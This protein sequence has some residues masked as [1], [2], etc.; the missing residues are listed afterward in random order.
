VTEDWQFCFFVK[1]LIAPEEGVAFDNVLI[2]GIPQVMMR[3]FSS[4]CQLRMQMMIK[5]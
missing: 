2:K 1:G 5:K 4:K 3:L